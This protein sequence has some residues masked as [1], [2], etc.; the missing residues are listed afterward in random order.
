MT[1]DEIAARMT[2]QVEEAGPGRA[3]AFLGLRGHFCNN[4][5]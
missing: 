2:G 4:T 1:P 5:R 3:E